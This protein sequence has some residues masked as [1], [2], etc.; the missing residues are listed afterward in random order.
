MKKIFKPLLVFALALAVSFTTIGNSG[1]FTAQAYAEVDRS[2]V[3]Y[4]FSVN[5]IRTG[6]TRTL[7][8]GDGKVHVLIFG[9]P[10]T[11]TRTQNAISCSSKIL[12]Y[13]DNTKVDITALN[14]HRS[15]DANALKQLVQTLDKNNKVCI[16][17]YNSSFYTTLLKCYTYC[18]IPSSYPM[19]FIVYVNGAGRI[20]NWSTG[21][22]S[23]SDLLT[24]LSQGGISN[25]YAN[26]TITPDVVTHTQQ[27]IKAF[28]NSH[29]VTFNRAG[30]VS[31]PSV[32]APYYWGEVTEATLQDAL[33]AV[34]QVRYIAG[35]SSNIT[36]DEDYNTAA[37]FASLVN[38]ANGVLSHYPTQPAGMSDG[39][40][41]MAT[42]GAQN[43]NLAMGFSSIAASIINGYMNDGDQGNISM[44]GHRR[45]VLNP[46][47][48]KAGFG[49]VPTTDGYSFYSAMFSHDSSGG[50]NSTVSM[51]PAI[52]TPVEYFDSSY[53]WSYSTGSDEN[54]SNIQVEVKNNTSGQTWNFSQNSS[55]GYF[56]VDNQGFGLSGCIIFRP[57]NI[58]INDGDSYHVKI[59]GTTEMGNI[60]YDVNFFKLNEGSNN[61]GDNNGGSNNNG[62]SDNNGGSNNN[63]ESDNNGGSNNNGGNNNNGG[64]GNNG[65]NGGSSVNGGYDVMFRLYNPNS[66]EHFYTKD[67]NERDT[68]TIL[69]WNYEGKGWDAPKSG[70]PVYRLYNKNAGDHHYTTN[71][72]EKDVLITAGWT[73]EGVA[74][75]S[76]PKSEGKPLYRLYNPNATSGSHHYTENARERDYLVSIG[77]KDEGIGWYGL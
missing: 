27:E 16:S 31:L 61:S 18:N 33:N 17:D 38:S 52:N 8:F 59:S 1:A 69:G 62:G 49:I 32:Q 71:A 72:N 39:M 37:Q 19:P 15:S 43:S 47:M 20:Y 67:T 6:S 9:T 77:W 55:N 36:L 14:I 68:L 53:P 30:F 34:N 63:G 41:D 35:L 3:G 5:D 65:S 73:Y 64:S 4:G 40:F 76:A 44:V 24:N 7:S 25:T 66:G 46:T 28:A 54:I 42:Y 10:L 60:E 29:P 56:N 70:D 45:W 74:W 57:S 22:V 75:Y 26:R 50:S 11:C 2:L 12:P 13:V 21:A 58:Q 51:W 23:V 48:G